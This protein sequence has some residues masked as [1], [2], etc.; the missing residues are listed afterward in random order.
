MRGG[1]LGPSRCSKTK[2]VAESTQ[3]LHRRALVLTARKSTR[4]IFALPRD[5]RTYNPDHPSA[6]PHRS[7]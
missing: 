5:Y 4:L 2:K 7:A 1:A 3:F 6:L